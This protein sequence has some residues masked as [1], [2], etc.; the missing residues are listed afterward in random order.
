[1]EAFPAHLVLTS[2]WFGDAPFR[3]QW[4][5]LLTHYLLLASTIEHFVTVICKSQYNLCFPAPFLL[6]EYRKSKLLDPVLMN[7]YIFSR[8][9]S[10]W[11]SYEP[12][13]CHSRHARAVKK[14]RCAVTAVSTFP[15]CT[16]HIVRVL[17]F[18]QILAAALVIEIH[19]QYTLNSSPP[20]HLPVLIFFITFFTW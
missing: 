16:R 18:N 7:D 20:T 12:L 8:C 14:V 4:I 15:F 3:P 17:S 11:S 5:T 6:I 19:M 1:M 10:V 2:H 9:F 13:S